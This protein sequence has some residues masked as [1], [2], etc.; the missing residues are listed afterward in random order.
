MKIEEK[1]YTGKKL[2]GI[3]FSVKDK[4]YLLKY[5]PKDYIYDITK[6]EKKLK[7]FGYSFKFV[8]AKYR[9]YEIV[10]ITRSYDELIDICRKKYNSYIWEIKTDD[11][12]VVSNEK[13]DII[14]NDDGITYKV[15]Y[16]LEEDAG[17]F[18]K[19]GE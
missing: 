14:K 12:N 19:T 4:E 1:K 15:T 9:E 3:G 5:L 10:E 16:D 13:I 6:K 2:Y 11:E 8:S 18:K 7:L 17:V